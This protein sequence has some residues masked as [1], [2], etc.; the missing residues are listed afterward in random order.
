MAVNS[1]GAKLLVVEDEDHVRER[2]IGILSDDGFQVKQALKRAEIL[3]VVGS[4]TISAIVLDLGLPGDDGIAIVKVVRE[5]SDIPILILTGR[6][7]VHHR[8]A[9]L[10]A[11]ADDYVVKPFSPEELVARVRALLRRAR[12]VEARLENVVAIEIGNTRIDLIG[13]E[14]VGPKGVVK[15]TD[16]ETRLILTL[17]KASGVLS[18]QAIYREAYFRDWNPS[19]RSIDVHITNL[20]KKFESIS[21]VKNLIPSVR[22]RGYQLRFP[23][24]LIPGGA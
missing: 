20:R 5:S 13:R 10:E 7:G 14:M 4:N 19:D 18:R 21:G 17:S 23:A 8:V 9:G 1:V 15:L 12:P 22:A 3:D 11:G 16:R 24:T 2:I 6:A